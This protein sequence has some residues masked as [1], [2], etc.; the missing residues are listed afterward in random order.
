MYVG[1]KAN[2]TVG[3]CNYS[4]EVLR[5]SVSVWGGSFN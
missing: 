5:Q 2:I 1:E 4:Q 3:N